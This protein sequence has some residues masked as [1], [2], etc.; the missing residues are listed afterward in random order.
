MFVAPAN[1]SIKAN[2]LNHTATFWKY[3]VLLTFRMSKNATYPHEVLTMPLIKPTTLKCS[4]NSQ[5]TPKLSLKCFY[6]IY[7]KHSLE[8]YFWLEMCYFCPPSTWDVYVLDKLLQWKMPT[9]G[10]HGI[11]K[12]QGR[13][14]QWDII[15]LS[16]IGLLN[17]YGGQV[18]WCPIYLQMLTF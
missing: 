9:E 2:F 10:I 8:E 7:P 4:Q 5:T 11:L 13:H 18:L 3:S 12:A 6:F 16:T 14:P 15:C 1:F 17:I